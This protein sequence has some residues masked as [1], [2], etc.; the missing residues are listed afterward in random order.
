MVVHLEEATRERERAVWTPVVADIDA[1]ARELP[2]GEQEV[3]RAWLVRLADLLA[4][5]P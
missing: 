2:P 4:R 1:A 5:H 3:V